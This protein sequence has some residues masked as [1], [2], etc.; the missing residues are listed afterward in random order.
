MKCAC[1]SDLG[2]KA[3]KA[4]TVSACNAYNECCVITSADKKRLPIDG[5]PARTDPE[6][7][8]IDD[9]T[10]CYDCSVAPSNPVFL[11]FDIG[12]F[13][14]TA[15]LWSTDRKCVND[16]VI[17]AYESR[18][19]KE[20]PLRDDS[21]CGTIQVEPM[22]ESAR[23]NSC[24]DYGSDQMA[25]LIVESGGKCVSFA[26]VGFNLYVG[27]I[28]FG[29]TR[30]TSGANAC[31]QYEVY[32]DVRDILF[33]GGIVAACADLQ[34]A[35]TDRPTSELVNTCRSCLKSCCYGAVE[36]LGFDITSDMGS[37]GFG[38]ASAKLTCDT[39]MVAPIIGI[40]WLGP[41]KRQ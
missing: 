25:K 7:P 29:A 38:S 15:T 20:N 32:K 18:S 23:A 21:Y 5:C 35:K 30:V 1:E 2:T 34:V 31:A 19:Y 26:P 13:P 40:E 14:G 37:G 12:C 11:D 41:D 3:R 9:D 22:T 6:D 4:C 10:P 36:T 17:E 27:G 24:R 16:E 28:H 39:L 33:N 8:R